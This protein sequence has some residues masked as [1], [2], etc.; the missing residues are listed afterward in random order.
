MFVVKLCSSVVKIPKTSLLAA[1]AAL[2][3]STAAPKGPGIKFDFFGLM[4]E[5]SAIPKLHLE[6]YTGEGAGAHVF[7]SALILPVN[8]GPSAVAGAVLSLGVWHGRP[9]S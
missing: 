3:A 6:N 5:I 2:A 9:S 4:I 1:A 8:L 7:R